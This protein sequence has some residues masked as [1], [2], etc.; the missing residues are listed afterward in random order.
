MKKIC[1]LVLAMTSLMGFCQVVN[2]YAEVTAV[3]GATLT[4]GTVDESADS[5][6]DGEWVVLMQM[7][8]D[9]IG[10]TTDDA[11]FGSLGSIQSCGLHEIRQIASHTESGGVPTSITLENTPNFSYNTGANESVQIITLREYG[12]PNYTTTAPMSALPWDGTLGGVL[13]IFVEGTLTLAHSMSADLGGFNGAGP[14]A[15]GSAGCS[16]GANYRLATT[17]NFADKGEGIYKFTDP[18]YAA[19]MGRIVTGGGGGNS[20]NGGGGGGSNF[21]AGGEAGPGWPT[22]SPSGGGLGGLDMSTQ[23]SVDRVFMGGGGG[24]GEGNNNLSTDGGN[25][26]GIILIR[27]NEISTSC[28]SS[29][30]I[31]SNGE[32]I[33]FAGND[34]GGGGGAAG[35]IVI[36]TNSW[37]VDAG[38]PLTIEAIGGDGGDVNS[39]STHGGGGGGGQGTVVFSTAEPTTNVTTTTAPGNG[40]CDNNSDPC[41][42][43]AGDGGGSPGD[44]IVTSSTGPLA[45]ELAEHSVNCENDQMVVRWTTKSEL[46]TDYFRIERSVDNQNWQ[47]LSQVKAAGNSSF[48]IDYQFVDTESLPRRSYYRMTEVDLDGVESIEFVEFAQ[49]CTDLLILYPNPTDSEVYLRLEESPNL[50]DLQVFNAVGQRVYPIVSMDVDIMTIDF[51]DLTG[52][53]YTLRFDRAGKIENHRLVLTQ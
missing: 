2:G 46:N 19:G 18:L 7:Q 21:S 41:N 29:V 6:E 35:S 26:G 23:I 32:S 37:S 17:D 4:L 49:I 36:E 22:C 14:N 34:G 50:V 28:A 43:Q 16:G 47:T 15:G 11:G 27:A 20:H 8:D 13:A 31:T 45:I 24:A 33:S 1:T 3:A 12:S 10:T 48:K 38:C 51:S 42:S 9:V 40:G 44:G 25:G 52:G 30:S 39:G 5:F 53:T